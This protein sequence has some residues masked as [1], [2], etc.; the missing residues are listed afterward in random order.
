MSKNA[1]LLKKFLCIKMNKKTR[2]PFFYPICVAFYSKFLIFY[3]K[4]P[5]R[6]LFHPAIRIVY[7]PFCFAKHSLQYTG[8]SFLG[9]KGTLST[10]PHEAQTISYISLFCLMLF[11]LA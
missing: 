8:L 6:Q 1:I 4:L 3:E 7:Q 2:R 5:E 10:L 9:S 11:F